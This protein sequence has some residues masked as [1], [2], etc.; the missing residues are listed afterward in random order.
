MEVSEYQIE[1]L[2]ECQIDSPLGLPVSS[3]AG[4]AGYV[5]DAVRIIVNLEH[6]GKHFS[7]TP[8][9]LEK[10][11]P[12]A[13]IYFRPG[14]TRAAITTCGGLSRSRPRAH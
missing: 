9:T 1:S 8:V 14:Y 7:E 13:K 3:G 11:G 5:S 6:H 4:V 10:A 2:G 12:R